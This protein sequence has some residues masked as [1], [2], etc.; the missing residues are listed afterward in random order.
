MDMQYFFKKYIHNKFFYTGFL[1]LVWLI[2]FD[3]ENLIEQHRLRNS[4]NDLRD[5]KEFYLE[6]TAENQQIIHLLE[7]DSTELETLAREK[8]Y[9]K[10]DNEDVFV[11]VR[12]EDD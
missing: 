6:E 3:Q 4:L 12:E 11:I 7:T 5:Q 10:R 9:M 2:F 1:F 8:Y